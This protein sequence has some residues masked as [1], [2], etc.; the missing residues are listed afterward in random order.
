MVGGGQVAMVEVEGRWL[1]RREGRWQWRD[2]GVG[3]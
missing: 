1:W 3:G 2:G